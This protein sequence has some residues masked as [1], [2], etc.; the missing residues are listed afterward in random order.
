MHAGMADSN[1]ENPQ[2]ANPEDWPLPRVRPQV[3]QDDE[4]HYTCGSAAPMVAIVGIVT[5]LL[6]SMP[7]AAPGRCNY[8]PF[9][10]VCVT[11]LFG[12]LGCTTCASAA[13]LTKQ[14]RILICSDQTQV[15]RVGD[16][17]LLGDRRDS[18]PLY[19]DFFLHR[20]VTV[21]D[22]EQG[23]HPDVPLNQPLQRTAANL[24]DRGLASAVLACAL[25]YLA[26]CTAL[27]VTFTV[28]YPVCKDVQGTLLRT[29]PALIFGAAGYFVV[30]LY[31]AG[32]GRLT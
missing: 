10:S 2:V 1:N 24:L 25:L 23:G 26:C 28:A 6:V 22:D 9:A 32:L 29:V 15:A 3:R 19:T 11:L 18:A 27:I 14:V 13:T 31:R 20:D 30:A 4:E 12:Y 21:N 16:D 7:L 8:T 5:L 17:R